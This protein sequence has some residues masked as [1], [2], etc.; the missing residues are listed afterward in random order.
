[1]PPADPGF[2]EATKQAFLAG[3]F[4]TTAALPREAGGRRG[5]VRFGDG[6]TLAVPLISLAEAYAALDKGDPPPCQPTGAGPASTATGPDGTVAHQVPGGC[7][8]LEVTN[9]AL[10]TV[11]LRTSRGVAT[12]PAW[13]FTVR[14]LTGPIA[15]VSV[16]PP[17]ISAV[18]KANPTEPPDLPGLVRAED[19]TA[20]DGAKLTYRLGVGACDKDITALLHETDDV[21]VVG[22]S[23]TRP[24]GMCTE[25]LVLHPVTAA[26]RKPL[27]GR[28][29]LDVFTGQPLGLT[30]G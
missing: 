23:V 14:G 30:V 29:V 19:L 20:V 27:A 2:T 10:G 6:A 1:M 22:G 7:T 15:R 26:L 25:Q 13:L 21:V 8:A 4:R 5:T 18:P 3:W 12:V 9:V 11:P 16:A 17:A 24:D 28:P